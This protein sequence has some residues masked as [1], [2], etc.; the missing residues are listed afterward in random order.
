[1]DRSDLQAMLRFAIKNDIMNKPFTTVFK[2]YNI[3]NSLVY[4]E[5]NMNFINK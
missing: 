3:S 5:S 4:N 1:M 2:W